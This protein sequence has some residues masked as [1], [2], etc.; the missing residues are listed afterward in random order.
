MSRTLT[1]RD[2]LT[3]G[4]VAVLAGL[5]GCSSM[6]PFVGKRIENSRTIDPGGVD[7]LGIDLARGDV[8]LQ[9]SERRTVAVEYV[10][11]S[12]SV[13]VDLSKLRFRT[14]RSGGTLRLRSEWTGGDSPFGGRPQLD[15][16]A[17]VPSTLSVSRVETSVGDVSVA[18][19]AGDITLE[20]ETGDVVVEGVRGTVT[21]NTNT[22]DVEVTDPQAIGD[23]RTN[24]GDVEAD[25]PAIDGDTRVT[26]ETGDVT[27]Y[28]ASAVDADL[29]ARTETGT[30]SVEGLSLSDA[31][32]TSDVVGGAV[33]GS[34]GDGGPRLLL[35]TETGD[36]TVSALE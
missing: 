26:T 4:A 28:V 21:A 2:L 16:D 20:S 9:T 23:L 32:R 27:V 6:T 10:K 7:E 30:V 29:V 5:A 1:R 18:G 14:S 17:T 8:T 22:G 11:Q 13:Q 36:V 31:E 15:L 3:G 34:L 12:S 25:V 33:R 19:T 35:E 24:T